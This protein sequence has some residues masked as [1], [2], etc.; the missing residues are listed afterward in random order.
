MRINSNFRLGEA[1]PFASQQGERNSASASM[2]PD[3]SIKAGSFPGPSI[4]GRQPRSTNAAL[5]SSVKGH[6]G[7]TESDSAAAS[8]NQTLPDM[9]QIRN[10]EALRKRTFDAFPKPYEHA[11]AFIKEKLE[12]LPAVKEYLQRNRIHLDPSRIYFNVFTSENTSPRTFNGWEHHEQPSHSMS[13]VDKVMSNFSATEQ[14]LT[15]NDIDSAS[16]VYFAGPCAGVYD[17]TNELPVL[18]SQL[19]EISNG[20]YEEHSRLLTKFWAEQQDNVRTLDRVDFVNGARRAYMNKT[21]SEDDYK[22]AMQGGA[23]KVSLFGPIT[24]EQLEINHKPQPP[25]KAYTLYVDGYA[26]TDIVFFQSGHGRMVLYI[27]G[28]HQPFHGFDSREAMRD[29]LH[30]QLSSKDDPQF[31]TRI[32]RHFSLYQRQDGTFYSGVDT[33]LRGIADGSWKKSYIAKKTGHIGNDVFTHIAEE[34]RN[35]SASDADT[36]IKSDDEVTVDRWIGGLGD[37]T[38]LISPFVLLG[39]PTLLASFALQGAQLLLLSG[40]AT[41]GDTQPERADASNAIFWNAVGLAIYPAFRA[42]KRVVAG[43]T[44][45]TE[46]VGA[47]H[48]SDSN[49]QNLGDL[50]SIVEEDRQSLL[51]ARAPEIAPSLPETLDGLGQVRF[52]HELYFISNEPNFPDGSF[53][54]LKPDVERP[55]YAVSSG[56]VVKPYADWNWRVSDTPSSSGSVSSSNTSL[57]GDMIEL[58]SISEAPADAYAMLDGQRVRIKPIPGGDTWRVDEPNDPLKTTLHGDV[59][60]QDASGQWERVP[61]PSTTNPGHYPPTDTPAQARNNRINHAFRGNPRAEASISPEQSEKKLEKLI[62]AYAKQ[63]KRRVYN[64]AQ[65]KK[66]DFS[67]PETV[68]RGHHGMLAPGESGLVRASTRSA[69]PTQ[70]DDYLVDIIKHTSR[71]GGS[72][73][74]VLSLSAKKNIATKFARQN[75]GSTVYAIDTTKDPA[76]FRTVFDIILHDGP[77]L[78]D[79]GKLKIGTLLEA[80]SKSAGSGE[81]ELFYV[82]GDIPGAWVTPLTVPS[83]VDPG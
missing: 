5:E 49:D 48:K 14:S 80:I 12:A 55:G 42:I 26:S 50:A 53:V 23:P 15:P 39:A 3:V 79:A 75:V 2:A 45:E 73:G 59:L 40:K 30:K 24:L 47:T 11:K 82:D 70:A 74:R 68:Y 58:Q 22:I 44:A 72:Q 41:T 28:E 34:K 81:S 38:S 60:Q 64:V 71:G 63:T 56:I 51:G 65:L 66:L 62:K 54:L 21:L 31:T 43:P 29:W 13:L 46:Q 57:D 10:T 33:A 20:F 69:T 61:A 1:N 18:S 16:G 37:V 19:R 8:T 76:G 36:M 83:P 78:V 4:P 7:T 9:E 25:V 17:E 27:P 67:V 35:R 32:A 52:N 6:I 77:R